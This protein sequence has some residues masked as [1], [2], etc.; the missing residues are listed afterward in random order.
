MNHKNGEA[1]DLDVSLDSIESSACPWHMHHQLRERG[2][3]VEYMRPGIDVP[4]YAV[5]DYAGVVAGLQKQVFVKN[6]QAAMAVFGSRET[7]QRSGFV[8]SNAGYTHLL[9]TDPPDHTRLRRLVARAFAPRRIMTLESRI[10]GLVD[11]LL[12]D[13][14]EL[15]EVDLVEGFAYQLSITMICE[16]LGIP[17]ERRADFRE[18]SVAATT[19]PKGDG[20]ANREAGAKLHDFLSEHIAGERKALAGTVEKDAPNVLASMILARDN[21]DQLSDDE[22]VGMAFL[23]FI[24]GHETTVGLISTMAKGLAMFPE[25]RQKIIDNPELIENAVEEFLRWD[26][27]VQRSTFRVSTEDVQIGE[28]LVPKGGMVSMH[29]GGANHDPAV[30]PN[31]D[32]VDVER[33][34]ERHVAFGQGI[35]FCVGAPLARL[36]AAVAVGTLVRRFPDYEMLV[37]ADKLEY[38]PTVVRALAHL[39]V[40]LAPA[41]S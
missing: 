33:E 22:L 31:P 28:G 1:F 8:L 17:S 2:E 40:R 11:G 35:H 27:P 9:N 18:W 5:T 30:F 4:L 15:D 38:L 39:P 7:A 36:E 37:P 34:L 19:P 29:I 41:R 21:D 6:P 16:I 32:V 25:Q 23:L 12:D 13:L 20:N 24:A 3:V 26:G 10:Q 14:A